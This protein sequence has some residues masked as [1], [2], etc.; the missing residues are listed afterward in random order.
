MAFPLQYQISVNGRHPE[1]NLSHAGLIGANQEHYMNRLQTCDSSDPEQPFSLDVVV[2]GTDALLGK[3]SQRVVASNF[4]A[5]AAMLEEFEHRCQP[6]HVLS[7][8]YREH[9]A[10]V[11]VIWVCERHG[12]STSEVGVELLSDQ[13]CPWEEELYRDQPMASEPERN[14]RKFQRVPLTTEIDMPVATTQSLD[15]SAGGMFVETN[16]VIPVGTLLTIGI[17][18]KER[19]II[20][21]A[22]VRSSRPGVG[23]GIEFLSLGEKE[24]K[25]I[26]G[27]V[28]LLLKSSVRKAPQK[29]D[30]SLK[31]RNY[32]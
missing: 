11:R 24:T 6:G 1:V 25:A 21:R 27:V 30:L 10:R 14:R 13:V 23:I 20:T 17:W 7:I 28:D 15:M 31:E 2:V 4:G 3:Y 9:E 12:V 8:R 22:I 19:R 16:S 5:R 29:A 18:V 26:E 32:E